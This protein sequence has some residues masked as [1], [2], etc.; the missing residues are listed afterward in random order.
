MRPASS[1]EMS[2]TPVFPPSQSLSPKREPTIMSPPVKK[3]SPQPERMAGVV[4]GNEAEQN[5]TH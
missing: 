2:E 1:H 3:A 5:G 4:F